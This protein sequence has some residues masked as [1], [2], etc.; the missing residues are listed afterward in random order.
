MSVGPSPPDGKER[1]MTGL[2]KR[3]VLLTIAGAAVVPSLLLAQQPIFRS[4]VDL[5]AVDTQVIDRDGTPIG[6]LAAKNFEV[7][8]NGQ[9]RKVVSADLIQ[10]P[11]L[12]P[13]SIV[14]SIFEQPDLVRSDV[15]EVRGR[16]IVLVVDE[17]SFSTQS[18]PTVIQTAKK[19]LSTLPPDDVI[20]LYAYPFGPARLDLTHYHNTVSLS[21]NKL[22]GLRQG[23]GGE[24]V[25]SPSEAIDMAADDTFTFN[26]VVERECMVPRKPGDTQTP[27]AQGCVIADLNCVHRLRAEANAYVGWIESQSAESFG[28]LRD[29]LHQLASIS[30]PKTVMLLSAGLMTADRVGARPDVQSMMSVAGKYAAAA[31]AVVY[32]LHV[33]GSYSETYSAANAVNTHNTQCQS[34]PSDMYTSQ[35]RDGKLN[36][37]GLERVAAEAGGEYFRISA[38]TGELFFNRVLKETSAYY[39]LGVQ[40]ESIDRDGRVHFIRVKAVD[41]KGATVRARKQVTIPRDGR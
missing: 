27:N 15:P 5:V 3:L 34:R 33:D 11:L 37:F 4:K 8:I 19:F 40:P 12:V 7:W 18:L 25:M 24:F 22:Q 30:G 14:P 29:L 13:R 2:L 20:G 41:V 38:G 28:G 10:Y 17:L 23:F 32:A 36:A 35:A 1:P 9:V 21:L 6:N 26:S 39:L 16:I 31:N